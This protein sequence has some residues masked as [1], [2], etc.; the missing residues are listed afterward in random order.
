MIPVSAELAPEK[1]TPG[2]RKLVILLPVDTPSPDLCKVISSAVALGYPAPILVN[3]KNN[4]R[5]DEEGVG[6]SHLGKITGTLDYLNWALD[7]NVSGTEGLGADDLVLMMD[8]HDVWLQ[9]SPE[10]LLNRYFRV[11][12]N[13][14][15]REGIMKSQDMRHTIVVSAQKGCFGPRDKISDLHCG[16]LPEST[17]PSNV[18]GFMTDSTLFNWNSVRPRFVN[19]G[20]FMGPAGDMRR[21]FERVRSRMEKDLAMLTKDQHLGGDQGL[22]SEIFAEQEIWRQ[23]VRDESARRSGKVTDKTVAQHDEYEYHVGL[24]YR[25]EL[26]YPTCY[27]EKDGFFVQLNDS[28]R[29]EKESR[30]LGVSPPRIHGLPSDMEEVEEPFKDITDDAEELVGWGGLPLYADFWTAYVPAAVHH[31]AWKDGLKKRRTTWWDKMWYFPRLRELLDAHSAPNPDE[32]LARLQAGRDED[33]GELRIWPSDLNRNQRL[34]LLLQKESR[35]GS[36]WS[37]R[38]A[39]WDAVCRY[40]DEGEE[41]NAGA[42]QRR[43]YDEVFRD[44]KGPYG[45]I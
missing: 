19:S 34:P 32:P 25:Q 14:D 29:I 7:E 15:T 37:L 23:K 39:A 44:G 6:P 31:N 36:D 21:F 11:T 41:N 17:L 13:A 1:I 43:W 16:S 8:A 24:D 10:I 45:N 35:A 40:E 4:F 33:Q 22:F 28:K 5:T 2:D 9:L 42:E 30:R 38:E 20:S 12:Q 27:S 26:F 3:W 18:Y